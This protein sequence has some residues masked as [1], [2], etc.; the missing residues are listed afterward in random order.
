M[1]QLNFVRESLTAA[2]LDTS[3]SGCNQIVA[4]AERAMSSTRFTARPTREIAI[5]E[6]N[7]VVVEAE[8]V[9]CTAGKKFKTSSLPVTPAIFSQVSWR[10]AIHK[11]S[12]PYSA[13]LN[14]CYGDSLSFEHQ[15]VLTV[16]VW[17]ALQVYQYAETMPKMSAKV[18][19][20]L[21]ALAW[22]SI[23]EA[24]SFIN[25]GECRYKQE[26]LSHLCGVSYDVWKKT[27][28]QRW[29]AILACSIQLDREALIHVEQLRRQS[30]S[31]R[32]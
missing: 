5:D 14:Y 19:K 18:E 13:W 20:N 7:T 11:L 4:L 30:K 27:Y 1:L 25:R 22:L 17:S 12:V 3:K 15:Q 28:K 31:D 6:K 24:K 10:K 26:E 21:K 8:P 32:R 29:E 23:Q 9:R 2:L 16:H